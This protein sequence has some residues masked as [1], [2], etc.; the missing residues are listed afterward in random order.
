[1]TLRQA[2]DRTLRLMRDELD[3]ATPG[4]ALI[5][6]LVPRPRWQSSPTP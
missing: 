3:P 2:L 5:A 1:M 4:D 6:A